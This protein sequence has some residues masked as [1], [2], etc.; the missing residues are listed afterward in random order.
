MIGVMRFVLHALLIF[1]G[2]VFIGGAMLNF[3]K[4]EYTAFGINIMLAI[5]MIKM[6]CAT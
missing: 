3:N 5:L 4:K 2:G 1:G 6:L